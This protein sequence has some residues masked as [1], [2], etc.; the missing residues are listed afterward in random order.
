MGGEG[1]MI[2]GRVGQ[3][4]N[5]DGKMINKCNGGRQSDR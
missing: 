3:S 4:S 1:L 5:E 2:E